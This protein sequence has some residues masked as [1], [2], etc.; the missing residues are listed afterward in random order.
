MLTIFEKQLIAMK[1]ETGDSFRY[2]I[3]V[4]PGG[5][6]PQYFLPLVD[7]FF[8]NKKEDFRVL[9][10]FEKNIIDGRNVKST[11]WIS[12]FGF[13]DGKLIESIENIYS[14]SEEHTSELQSHSFISYAVFCLKK[15]RKKK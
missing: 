15:K 6:F 5:H 14:R 11:F 3:S 9:Y 12:P 2:R 4:S 8:K 10:H 13:N 7:I 1:I